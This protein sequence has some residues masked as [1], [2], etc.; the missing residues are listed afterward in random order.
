MSRVETV[1]LRSARWIAPLA[2]VAAV[3]ALSAGA[4]L[5]ASRPAVVTTHQTSRGKVLAEA[6]GDSL[7]MFSS[8]KTGKS[9]CTGSCANTWHPDLTSGTPRAAAGSGVTSKLLGT[10]KRANHVQQATYNGHPLYAF[11]G[12]HKPGQITG[13][14]ANQFGGHWYLVNTAGNAVKPKSSGG[15]V[16]HPLCQS[17]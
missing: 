11:A 16:C 14:G 8:D 15:T 1:A 5:A 17:Y 3:C 2:A 12:D 13:E 7:Y 4:V 9:N 10:A 6:N